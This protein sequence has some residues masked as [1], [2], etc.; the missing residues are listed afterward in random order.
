MI[1]PMTGAAAFANIVQL[2]GQFVTSRDATRNA[3][4]DE[5]IGWLQTNR[6]QELADAIVENHVAIEAV[7]KL[8]NSQHEELLTCVRGLEQTIGAFA[9]S[10]AAL[11]ILANAL[12]VE[13]VLSEQGR[14]I[15]RQIEAAQASKF[16]GCEH[17]N[18]I[19]Y[20]LLDGSRGE[21]C[22]SEERFI[23]DDLQTLVDLG[24]LRLGSNR[25][26]DRL[27]RLTRAGSSIGS[28]G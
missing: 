7:R 26:G 9:A 1:D 13:S 19:D 21:I 18:G 17:L 12:Q 4:Y 6:H 23:E 15:L 22:V 5:Y 27:F 16:L 24:L 28:M 2:L 14:S 3:T 10:S 25:K 11:V 8:L 20:V